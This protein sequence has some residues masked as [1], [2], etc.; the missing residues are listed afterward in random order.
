MIQ[1]ENSK[2]HEVIENITSL[3]SETFPIIEFINF[4]FRYEKQLEFALSNINLSIFPG[5]IILLG[6]ISGSGKSTLCNAISGRIPFTISGQMKGNLNLFK[7]I[8]GIITKKKFHR[9]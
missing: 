7:K 2:T 4:S 6:G 3:D 8:F 5:E 9:R 1:M